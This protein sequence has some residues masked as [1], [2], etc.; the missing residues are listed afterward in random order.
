[1]NS[2]EARIM[3]FAQRR[4][5]GRKPLGNRPGR[6]FAN[7]VPMDDAAMEPTTSAPKP[8]EIKRPTPTRTAQTPGEMELANEGLPLLG[9]KP[10]TREYPAE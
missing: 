10:V 2:I 9:E 5:V 3:T 8:V 6:E 4:D 7:H 1:L